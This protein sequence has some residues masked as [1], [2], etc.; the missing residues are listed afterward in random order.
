MDV[1]IHPRF[2]PDYR[3]SPLVLVDVGAR[4]GLKGNWTPARQHLR[5]LGFEPDR[6]EFVRLEERLRASGAPD[7]YF[8]TALHNTAGEMTLYVA[9]DGGLSS[10][11]RPNREF[12]DGFPDAD[13]FDTV[14]VRQVR[15]DTLDNVLRAAGIDDVDFVKTDTQ[16]SELRVL[17]GGACILAGSVFGV[18]VEVE[19]APVYTDQP[20]FADVDRYLRGLGFLLFDL[21]PCYWKRAAGRAVGG[22]LGQMIWADALYFKSVPAL[23]QTIAPLPAAERRGKVLRAISASLLYG[24]YDYAL[25]LTAR[26]ADVFDADERRAIETALQ[27][28]G[29]EKGPVPAFPGRRRLAVASRWLWKQLVQKDDAWSVSGANLGN[30]R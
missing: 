6:D 15:A 11:Y 17:E 19:F 14:D 26:F 28:A 18:E 1:F 4:G 21:R 10:I 27:A 16:G 20:L 5:L 12:L 25:E 30:L 7:R 9:R 8:N 22:P 2:E 13:R 23:G 24:Y 29:S 3:R